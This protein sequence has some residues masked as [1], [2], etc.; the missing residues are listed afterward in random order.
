MS[1]DYAE[2]VSQ[3]RARLHARLDAFLPPASEPPQGLHEAMRYAVL[4]GGKRIRPVLTL[5]TA[6]ALEAQPERVLS[7]AA[8]VE[9][10]HAYSLVHD[11]LPAMD[12]DRERR[13]RPTVHVKFG[14]A[15][16]ILCGDALL[17]EA[18]RALATE[19][20][21]GAVVARLAEA[22]GSRWL[23]GGQADDLREPPELEAILSVHARKTAALFRFSTWAAARLLHAADSQLDALE[24]MGRHYGLAFQLIDDLEDAGGSGCSILR[25]LDVEAAR[26][27]AH[28]E[29]D[30]ARTALDPLGPAADLLRAAVG[31]LA[32]RIGEGDR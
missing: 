7:A 13:G 10:V 21:P 17:A 3:S 1:S 18:F 25:V 20:V 2:F 12:D 32:G 26:E 15:L 4:S 11:D 27:R 31:A 23:V 6:H 9:L 24:R 29:L 22:T 8:A 30:A 14:E 5:A 28:A 16:A 19:A